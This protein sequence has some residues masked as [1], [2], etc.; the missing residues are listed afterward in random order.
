MGYLHTAK[1]NFETR[2]EG[3]VSRAETLASE[4]LKSME[5][6][7][8]KISNHVQANKKNIESKL[9][10]NEKSLANMTQSHVEQTNKKMVVG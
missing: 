8:S 10:T 9:E 6:Q 1:K 3:I 2:S 7:A 4:S 5:D